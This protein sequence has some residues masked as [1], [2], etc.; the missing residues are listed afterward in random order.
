MIFHTP[1][2]SFNLSNVLHCPQAYANLLSINQ[3][4]RDNNC[5]FFLLNGSHYFVKD[6]LTG[7]TLLEGRSQGGLYLLHL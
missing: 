6:N 4:C 1:N 5:F 7:I 3:F 2:S